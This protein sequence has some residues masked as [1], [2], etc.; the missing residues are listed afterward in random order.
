MVL[1]AEAAP[2][3][4][5]ALVNR[6]SRVGD[7]ERFIQLVAGAEAH[8]VRAGPVRGVEGEQARLKLLEA[9]FALQAGKA[10]AELHLLARRIS[11]LRALYGL[12]DG[13]PVSDAEGELHGV[14]EALPRGGAHDDAVHHD[15]D[16]MLLVA[17][18]AELAGL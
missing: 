3:Q 10:L 1:R 6:H 2:G 5:G 12:H 18:E 13:D 4:D 16:G 15:F 7:D 14:G 9:A 17:C 8:A 11:P